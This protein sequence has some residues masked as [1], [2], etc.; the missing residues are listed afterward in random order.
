MSLGRAPFQAAAGR[1]GDAPLKGFGEH[2]RIHLLLA[3]KSSTRGLV[4]ASQSEITGAHHGNGRAACEQSSYCTRPAPMGLKCIPARTNLPFCRNLVRNSSRCQDRFRRSAVAE[5]RYSCPLG[6]FSLSATAW[7]GVA[8]VFWTSKGQI[9]TST[10]MSTTAGYACGGC[11][12][13]F[14]ATFKKCGQCR[15][16]VYCDSSCQKRHW[17]QG[18][19]CLSH[20]KLPPEADGV[21]NCVRL[22]CEQVMA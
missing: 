20:L 3:L 6:V 1:P 8:G 21:W 18:R 7:S 17:K 16:A 4:C 19:W 13:V 14:Q 10:G 11:G 22:W 9:H 12:S 15:V 2:R 5:G